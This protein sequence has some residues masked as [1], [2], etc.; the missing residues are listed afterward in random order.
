MLSLRL[1]VCLYRRDEY[2]SHAAQLPRSL[3]PAHQRRSAAR[4]SVEDAHEARAPGDTADSE[5]SIADGWSASRGGEIQQLLM[6]SMMIMMWQWHARRPYSWQRVN[7]EERVAVVDG[8]L[9]GFGGNPAV[10]TYRPWHS[11]VTRRRPKQR[12]LHRPSAH[13][14]LTDSGYTTFAVIQQTEEPSGLGS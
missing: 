2:V 5:I 4:R 7:L 13:P 3:S 8:C 1:C 9:H 10:I 6:T 11:I 14:L 12:R